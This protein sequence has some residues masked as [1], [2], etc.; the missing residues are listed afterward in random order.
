VLTR[1]AFAAS[2][3]LVM[4]TGVSIVDRATAALRV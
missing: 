4:S 1:T 2:Y 3:A